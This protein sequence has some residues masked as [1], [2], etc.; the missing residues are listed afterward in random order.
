M[1]LKLY[2]HIS[3]K[4]RGKK[5][6]GTLVQPKKPKGIHISVPTNLKF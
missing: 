1:L 2:T 6:Q 3:I 5:L 4:L